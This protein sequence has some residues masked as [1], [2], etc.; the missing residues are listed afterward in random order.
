MATLWA[1]A[2]IFILLL[3]LAFY[4]SRSEK[5]RVWGLMIGLWAATNV[6]FY[7]VVLARGYGL[8]FDGLTSAELNIIST[9]TKLQGALIAGGALIMSEVSDRRRGRGHK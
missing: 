3:A 8:V 4:A 5:R 2:A 7:A 9:A 6:V 1:S